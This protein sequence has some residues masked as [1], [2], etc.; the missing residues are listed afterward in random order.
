MLVERVVLLAVK[1]CQIFVGWLVFANSIYMC[2]ASLQSFTTKLPEVF[3][4]GVC[5]KSLGSKR[6]CLHSWPHIRWDT[7]AAGEA[8]RVAGFRVASR[9]FCDS[10]VLFASPE[11]D[12]R[13]GLKHSTELQYS[14]W[15]DPHF[16]FLH[17]QRNR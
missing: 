7:A 12:L 5:Y 4:K 3:V 15:E 2:F 14:F 10:I 9:L 1:A 17:I 8:K 6:I 13:C 11:R 16:F